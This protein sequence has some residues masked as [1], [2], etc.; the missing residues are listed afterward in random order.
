VKA[1]YASEEPCWLC[2]LPW[3]LGAPISK[4]LGDWVHEDCK[5]ARAASVA[6][7]GVRTELPT[8]L[9][10][11]EVETIRLHPASRHLVEEWS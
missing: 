2:G 8:V 5:A 1:K 11:P 4:W 7:E 10:D 9:P 3:A 6:S